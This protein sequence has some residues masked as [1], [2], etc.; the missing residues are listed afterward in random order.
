MTINSPEEGEASPRQTVRALRL[1]EITNRFVS[2]SA[3]LIA[4]AALV[5]AVYQTKL[6]RDQARATVRPYL[7]VGNSGNNGYARVVQNVG[8][9][10]AIIGAF[11]VRVDGH[12]M[13]TWAEV[14]DAMG[15][16]LSWKGHATTTFRPGIVAPQGATIDLLSLPDSNDVRIFRQ[17]LN[18]HSLETRV[19]YCSLYGDCWQS[20]PASYFPEPVKTCKENPKTMFAE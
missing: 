17:A 14:A 10:P 2:A 4:I 16:K 19:C 1:S 3:S 20:N 13:K 9:G 18:G 12:P 11:D 5:T 6:A 8:L 7:I 15:V